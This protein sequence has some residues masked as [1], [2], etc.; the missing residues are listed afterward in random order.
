MGIDYRYN[1]GYGFLLP[2]DK[3]AL[4]AEWDD[5]EMW[6]DGEVDKAISGSGLT[7]VL[8][9]SDTSLWGFMATETLG[10]LTKYSNEIVVPLRDIDPATV[11]NLFDIRTRVKRPKA[12]IGWTMWADIS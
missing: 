9:G 5:Y 11:S 1:A 12:R 8:G 10:K 3:F 4:P 2:L 6:W 7:A